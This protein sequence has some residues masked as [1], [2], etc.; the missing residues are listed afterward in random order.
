MKSNLKCEVVRDILP[1][2]V[3]NLTSEVTNKEIEKHL[4]ECK[5]CKGVELMMRNEI[6]NEQAKTLDK[7]VDFLKTIKKNT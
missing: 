6:V 4:N 1:L 7:E 5:E 2:Y 3:D